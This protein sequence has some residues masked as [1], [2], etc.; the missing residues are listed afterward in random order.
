ML[1]LAVLSRKIASSIII[2]SH[3]YESQTG[4]NGKWCSMFISSITEGNPS[5]GADLQGAS[6]KK[7]NTLILQEPN[8][9]VENINLKT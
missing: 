4:D 8:I 6:T 1:Y 3:Y 9:K 7:K 5:A 2:K